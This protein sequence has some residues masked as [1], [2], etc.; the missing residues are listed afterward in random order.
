[1]GDA[2]KNFF[3]ICSGADREI[4]ARRECSIESNKYVGIGA[5]ILSTAVLASASGGYAFYTVFKSVPL[6]VCA[7]LVWGAII[8]NIDRY[9]ISTIRKQST[10]ADLPPRRLLIWRLSEAARF[11]PRLLLAVFISVI[12]TRPLELKIFQSEIDAGIDKQINREL[13]E[14]Q[15]K[16]AAEF[17]RIKTLTDENEALR[18]AVEAKQADTRGLY[19]LAM[20][21][22]LG[23]KKGNTT[24]LYGPGRFCKERMAAYERS[25]VESRELKSSNEARA[26]ANEKELVDLR[27][28]QDERV[29]ESETL[30]KRAG[31][32]L[33]RLKT[34][35]SLAKEDTT[36]AATSWFLIL[37]FILLETAPILFKMLSARG[38]YEEIYDATE[39]R[40]R[41]AEQKGLSGFDSELDMQAAFNERLHAARLTAALQLSQQTMEGLESLASADVREAQAEVARQVVNRWK[42]AELAL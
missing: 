12:I 27:A 14:R 5:T 18:R 30:V 1:M 22:C 37:L 42:T 41:A 39:Y 32:L 2:V 7:G 16:I 26:A 15:E 31:G 8:F 36:V 29:R 9:I 28:R 4:L 34:L 38:P 33:A 21:E 19:D 20:A 6:A 23:E 35:S 24:G 10:P 40:V 25:D 13:V 17:P 11:A 3:H